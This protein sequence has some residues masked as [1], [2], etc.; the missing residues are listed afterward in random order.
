MRTRKT[1]AILA[2]HWTIALVVALTGCS[3]GAQTTQSTD[4]A[5]NTQSNS[6]GSASRP[7]PTAQDRCA[8][9]GVSSGMTIEGQLGTLRQSE[10]SATLNPALSRLQTCYAN[11]LEAHPYLAGAVQFKIR[12]GTDGSVRWVLP[13]QSSI[14]DR[15]TERCMT[16]V[17]QGLRFP[18]PCG[19]ETET[20][21][22]PSFEGGEDA[23]PA[24][25]WDGSRV[26]TQLSR[27]RAQLSQCLRGA[28]GANAEVTMYVGQGGRVVTAGASISSNEAAAAIDCLVSEVSGWTG[29]PD[30]G[31]YPAKATF[32][33]P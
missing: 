25:A 20:T 3:S 24:V 21:W 7:Q 11:R 29:L 17:L 15:E 6:S 8:A 18:Q 22:G 12:V 5:A 9:M 27:R 1:K 23:R 32:R 19:G 10:V 4:N 26:S 14:G 31:S 30:P 13:V 2:R 33:L 16:D 28:S